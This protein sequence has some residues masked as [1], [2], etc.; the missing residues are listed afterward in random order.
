MRIA[1][2]RPLS[3][4]IG[5]DPELFLVDKGSGAFRSAH[6]LLPGSKAMPYTVSKGAL[7][8]DGTAAEFNIDP[9]STSKEFVDNI[10][11]VLLDLQQTINA[12]N[13]N[14]S[15]KVVPTAMFDPEYFKSLPPD[16]LAFGCT[17]DYNAYSSKANEFVGTTKPMRTG[18]GHV[19]VGWTEGELTDD[20]GHIYDCM[21]AA[22]QLDAS[23]YFMSLLWDNDTR[24]REL[25]GQIG[26]FRPKS[27]GVE[28]RS[29]SNA[30]VADPDLQVYVFNATLHAIKL[31][32]SKDN[33]E[34]WQDKFMAE[35]IEDARAG[36]ESSTADLMTMHD[37]LVEDFDFPKLPE[38]YAS[39]LPF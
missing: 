19:H 6:D 20:P 16:A 24:R 2:V 26:A 11:S 4:T 13:P 23:L 28:Y 32:D 1:S 17:P 31:L 15:L 21:Q 22:R 8:P 34:L 33:V 37:I 3:Y 25:Y 12:K 18:A 27:Y 10:K 38:Y 29:V 5:C 7:Q 30:W 39:G 14:L 9:A 36:V 35:M